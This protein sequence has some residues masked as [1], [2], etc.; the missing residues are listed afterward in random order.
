MSEDVIEYG[1]RGEL[2]FVRLR[3]QPDD[4][5]GYVKYGEDCIHIELPLRVEVDTDF[6]EGRQILS[7]QEYLPQSIIDLKEVTF[8]MNEV[9]LITPIREDFVQQYRQ[10]SQFFYNNQAKINPPK[11]AKAAENVDVS[12][13]A[14]KVVSIL[15]AMANKKDKPVH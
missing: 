11:V 15:E 9:L 7:L 8:E 14:Q 1:S 5:V 3:Y 4:L 12:D 6:E 2:K 13:A 10:V